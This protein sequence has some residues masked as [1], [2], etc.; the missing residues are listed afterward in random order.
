MRSRPLLNR[1]PATPADARVGGWLL[2]HGRGL[3]VLV[4]LPLIAFLVARV[5][6]GGAA[7]TA[8]PLAAAAAA[9]GAAAVV[10]SGS[11]RRDPRT[12]QTWLLIAVGLA[13]WAIGQLV[14]VLVQASPV[15][16]SDGAALTP[17]PR[18]LGLANAG[19]IIMTPFLVAG[20]LHLLP[21][22]REPEPRL[23]VALDALIGFASLV[24][25]SWFFILYPI[26]S[27]GKLRRRTGGRRH[28]RRREHRRADGA[29]ARRLTPGKQA[30]LA[31]A[32][33][34]GRRRAR[35]RRRRHAHLA[36]ADRDR[37]GR[38]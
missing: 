16:G 31:V 9:A 35:L 4:G 6:G 32:R 12:R 24:T 36:G 15:P 37:I 30:N 33:R 28:P 11:R 21:S 2:Q 27:R 34:P 8:G 7:A 17:D 22:R 25:I 26:W 19:Y 14:A 10:V 18:S 1:G 20:I 29:L 3:L 23:K 5:I 13:L 38:A